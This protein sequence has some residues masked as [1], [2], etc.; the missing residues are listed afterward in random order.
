MSDGTEA[1]LR[2][3]PGDRVAAKWS[4]RTFLIDRRLGEGA[5]GSVYLV[6]EPGGASEAAMKLGNDAYALQSE[7][8]ALRAV[9]GEAPKLLLADDGTCR[10]REFPFYVMAFVPGSTLSASSPV[11]GADRVAAV[12][13]KLLVQL[14]ALHAAGWAFGDLKPDNVMID[15]AGEPRLVDYGGATRFGQGVKQFT[16]L[17]DRGF[18]RLGGRQAEPA[19]DL[20]A[21]AVSMLE[22]AGLGRRVRATANS[23]RRDKGKQLLALPDEAALPPAMKR[24]LRRL[25]RGEHRDCRRAAEAWNAA[26]AKRAPRPAPAA[27]ELWPAA[28][29]AGAFAAFVGVV[30]WMSGS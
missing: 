16:E 22:A 24:E 27:G 20:F 28:W 14:Q 30:W 29:F 2:L 15:R 5:N 26:A 13:A 7:I 12:G 9:G 6:R 10:G 25:L 21:F 17:Y 1:P 8:N 3:Q 19:Y 18:W 11:G 4:G 23:P